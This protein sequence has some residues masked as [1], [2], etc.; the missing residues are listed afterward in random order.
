MAGRKKYSIGVD[1]GGTNVT[2]ALVKTDGEIIRKIKL[3]L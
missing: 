2:V 3:Q 1:I